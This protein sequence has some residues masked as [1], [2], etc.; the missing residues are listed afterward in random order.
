MTLVSGEFWAARAILA[1]AEPS[2]GNNQPGSL[3]PLPTPSWTT[4][5]KAG[6]APDLPCPSSLDPLHCS[7]L[8]CLSIRTDGKRGSCFVM[9]PETASVPA[10]VDAPCV[11]P[12]RV[13]QPSTAVFHRQA[14]APTCSQELG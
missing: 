2:A 11:V 8:I 5:L 6:F 4:Q 3:R 1:G 9:E 14:S 7:L 13:L 12:V 10:G